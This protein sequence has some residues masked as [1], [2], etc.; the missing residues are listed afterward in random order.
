MLL[1]FS[2]KV[3]LLMVCGRIDFKEEKER[4]EEKDDGNE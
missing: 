1:L 4:R 3:D 2:S